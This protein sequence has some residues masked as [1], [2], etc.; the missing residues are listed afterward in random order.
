MKKETEAPPFN[1]AAAAMAIRK[2]IREASRSVP[3][4]IFLLADW[5]VHLLE[6][7]SIRKKEVAGS[8][9]VRYLD[10]LSSGFLALSHTIDIANADQEEVTDFY[11]HI[12]DP[13]LSGL[14]PRV[15]SLSQPKA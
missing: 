5:T 14:D 4:N 13:T 9:V 12:I 7:R 10:A 3:K 11:Q 15:A 8:T 1:R 6:R 2:A